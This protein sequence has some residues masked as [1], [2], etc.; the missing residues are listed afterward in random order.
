MDER[1]SIINSFISVTVNSINITKVTIYKRERILK[2][3]DITYNKDRQNGTR[4]HP[5]NYHYPGK[6]NNQ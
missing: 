1:Y 5:T 6:I 4:N 2:W 3:P